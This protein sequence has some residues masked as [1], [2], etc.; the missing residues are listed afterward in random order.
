MLIY[1]RFSPPAC[2]VVLDGLG[3]RGPLPQTKTIERQYLCFNSMLVRR[4]PR[5]DKRLIL[6]GAGAFWTQHSPRATTT[7][8]V[9][10]PTVGHNMVKLMGRWVR[11][12]AL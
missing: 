10:K 1:I 9:H 11:D 4:A 3:L 6:A 2:E 7:T 8:W 12:S 5:W